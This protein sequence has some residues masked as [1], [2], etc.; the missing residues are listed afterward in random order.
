[1]ELWSSSDKDSRIELHWRLAMPMV[2][3]VLG[4]LAVP[5]SYIAP[6]QGRF[7]K[8]GYA[9]LVY[10][11]YLNFMVITRAQLEAETLPIVINFWGV[12]LIFI[13][14]AGGLLYRRDRGAF[15]RGSSATA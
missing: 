9:L 14:L 10:F 7:G 11:A 15:S 12:H 4:I 3:L 2:L 1:M 6:R 8:V 5:L 13:T